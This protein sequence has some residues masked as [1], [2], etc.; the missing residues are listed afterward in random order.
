[1]EELSK[2]AGGPAKRLIICRASVHR[3]NP[4]GYE[5]RL[6]YFVTYTK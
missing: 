3:G 5:R 6:A 2:R 1:M 4:D